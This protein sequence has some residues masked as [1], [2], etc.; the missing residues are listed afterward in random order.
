MTDGDEPQYGEPVDPW[1]TG[2]AAAFGDGPGSIPP[3]GAVTTQAAGPAQATPVAG[4]WLASTQP[5]FATPPAWYRG[6]LRWIIAAA[7]VVVLGVAAGAVV[8]FWPGYPALDYRPL[9]EE[10]RVAPVVPGYFSFHASALRDGRAYFA[11]ADENG[12]LGVVA[13]ATDTGKQLW[14]STAA[15]T[16]R[17]ESF[18]VVAAAVV[19]ITGTDTA[20]ST[21]RVVLLDPENGNEL[22]ERRIGGSDAVHFIGD[23]MVL[24]DRTENRLLGFPIRGRG[25]AEWEQKSPKNQYGGADTQVAGVTTDADLLGPASTTGEAFAPPFDD[26]QRLVQIGADRSARV[27]DAATGAVL[28]RPRQGVAGPDDKVRAHDGRLIVVDSGDIPRIMAYD[29]A[30]LGEPRVLYTAPNA[31]ARFD[32]LTPCGADR[33]CLVETAGYDDK[34]ARVV[35]LDAAKGTVLWRR[36]VADVNGLVPFGDAVLATQDTSPAQSSLI[37]ADGKVVW[38]RTGLFGRLDAGNLL[39][40]SKALST[41]VDDPALFGGHLGDARVPLGALTG[42]RS[43]T[44]SWDTSHLACVADKDFVI[45][46]FAG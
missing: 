36:G 5:D 38:T 2:E 17:W 18:F 26:D 33:I 20:T 22:W 45:Q 23:S 19:A 7:T 11:A 16:G 25:K 8:Y 14:K 32:R 21:R 4:P 31:D 15:Q 43:S 24:V 30:K 12:N 9:A 46:R 3:S 40:F 44:C 1:A 39:Q 6:R 13:A 42:V 28:V 34:S 27:I 41:S 37:G 35:A 10:H 29:L